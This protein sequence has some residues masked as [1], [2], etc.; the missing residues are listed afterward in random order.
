[1]A[2]LR[3]PPALTVQEHNNNVQIIQR[4]YIT[5]N[6]FGNTTDASARYSYKILASFSSVVLRTSVAYNKRETLN[7]CATVQHY[8]F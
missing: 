1:M 2:A 5:G 3:P 4:S 6:T 8:T 7:R